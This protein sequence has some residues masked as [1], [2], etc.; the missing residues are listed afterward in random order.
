MTS[1]QA[2]Y[3]CKPGVKH[4]RVKHL[5]VFECTAYIHIPKNKKRKLDSKT[6]KCILL[7]YGSMQK[8]YRVFDLL[9]QK[10]FYSRNVKFHEQE[11]VMPPVEEEKSA[12]CPLV[13][14][15]IEES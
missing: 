11:L 2:W 1:H 10:V 15:P 12:W 7:G 3:G 6:K 13:L 9:T 14:D 8:G 4:L 5:R